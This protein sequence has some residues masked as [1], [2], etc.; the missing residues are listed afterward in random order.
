VANGAVYV[1]GGDDVGGGDK[2]FALKASAGTKLWSYRTR[3]AA[4]TTGSMRVMGI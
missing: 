2:M 3:G 4:L 1:G